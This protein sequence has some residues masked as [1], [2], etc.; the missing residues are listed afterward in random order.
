MSEEKDAA[1]FNIITG[2]NDH[3]YQ[4]LET[5]AALHNSHIVLNNPYFFQSCNHAE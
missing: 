3:F 2:M 5:Q 1:S 4:D